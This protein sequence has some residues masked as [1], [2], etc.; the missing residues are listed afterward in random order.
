M[1]AQQVIKCIYP[2]FHVCT[3]SS[4]V[5]M[6]CG[7]VWA[8]AASRWSF[9]HN[10]SASD[11][12]TTSLRISMLVLSIIM[13]M[14]FI[15][16]ISLWTVH[17]LLLMLHGTPWQKQ[18]HSSGS[19]PSNK[20]CGSGP[21]ARFNF[22]FQPCNSCNQMQILKYFPSAPKQN[23]RLMNLIVQTASRLDWV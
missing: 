21:S 9:G 8:K 6:H 20:S 2:S 14:V 22:C 19:T 7:Q 17:R 15:A 5:S 11:N 1:N 16:S 12:C 18:T 23:R 3:S 13:F 4:C 10:S